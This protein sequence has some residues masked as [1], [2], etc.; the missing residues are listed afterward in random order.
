[1]IV[2]AKLAIARGEASPTIPDYALDM[3][4]AEGQAMGRGLRHF[5][6]VGA[7]LNPQ[8]PQADRTYHQRLMALLDEIEPKTY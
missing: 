6:E 4:T 8:N 3:H 7:Q 5:F 1:M 2:W